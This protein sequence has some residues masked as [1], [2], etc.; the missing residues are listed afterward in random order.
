MRCL[1]T[2][3]KLELQ[4]L[5]D[6]VRYLHLSCTML[7]PR[8]INLEAEMEASA[9]FFGWFAPEIAAWFWGAYFGC[10]IMELFL[11]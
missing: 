5:H 11:C 8:T 1:S 7:T 9:M 6:L 3:V 4:R 2:S 10:E